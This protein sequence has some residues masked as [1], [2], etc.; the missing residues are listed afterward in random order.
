MSSDLCPAFSGF[1]NDLLSQKGCIL[2]TYSTSARAAVSRIFTGVPLFSQC[3]LR[4]IGSSCCRLD[5]RLLNKNACPLIAHRVAHLPQNKPEYRNRRFS[6]GVS[7][8]N[9]VT[10]TQIMT[11]PG[12]STK[13]EDIGYVILFHGLSVLQPAVPYASGQAAFSLPFFCGKALFGA[14]SLP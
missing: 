13:P 12:L 11:A 2:H 7:V 5:H 8:P 4:S 9:A 6:A 10:R 3:N 14:R 1:P